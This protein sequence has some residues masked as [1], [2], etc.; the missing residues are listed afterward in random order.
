MTSAAAQWPALTIS[1]LVVVVVGVVLA[2]VVR[3]RRK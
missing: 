3:D 1:L 2:W